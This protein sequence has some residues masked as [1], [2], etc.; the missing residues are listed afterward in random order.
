MVEYVT[1]ADRGKVLHSADPDSNVFT[2]AQIGDDSTDGN[3]NDTPL[4]AVNHTF[5]RGG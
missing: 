3:P 1:D 2:I 5:W 4:N